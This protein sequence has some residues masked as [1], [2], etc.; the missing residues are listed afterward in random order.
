MYNK[1]AFI[2][3]DIVVAIGIITN[4]IFWKKII[5]MRTFNATEYTEN[6]NGVLVFCLAKI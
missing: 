2:Q 3:D 1:I 5:L 6:L 4:P